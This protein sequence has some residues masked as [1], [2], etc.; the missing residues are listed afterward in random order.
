MKMNSCSWKQKL[1]S[2]KVSRHSNG[3]PERLRALIVMAKP[4]PRRQ[5]TLKQRCRYSKSFS[6]R[7]SYYREAAMSQ[8]SWF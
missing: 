3:P 8:K 6:G 7:C 5:H 2:P 4:Q 1:E